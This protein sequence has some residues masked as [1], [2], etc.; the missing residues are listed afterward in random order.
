[1]TTKVWWDDL[2]P[3]RI[4]AAMDASLE[5]LKLDHVDLY[6]VHWPAPDMDLGAVLDT[7]MEL[8]QAGLARAIGVS[9]FP[10]ALLE[11]AIAHGAPIACIQVEYHV[12]LSQGRL[13]AACRRHGVV[14]TGY[15][16]LAQ[17][18]VVEQPVLLEI[19][20]R[21][22]ASPAQIALAWLLSQEGVAAIPKA[23]R[24]DSQRANL[25]AADIRLDDADRTA[26]AALPKDQRFIK[27]AFAPIWDAP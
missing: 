21:H 26:I 4:R 12:L 15:S 13:L 9:N 23:A 24:P 6:L 22:G 5:A 11:R 20:R 2:T 10:V 19:A 27:P 8:K 16:P 1:V 18:Q 17:G 7:M 14:L 3:P 25:A